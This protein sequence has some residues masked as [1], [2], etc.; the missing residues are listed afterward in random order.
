MFT[1]KKTPMKIVVQMDGPYRVEGEIPLVKKIQVVTEDGEP[2]A[3]KKE[4]DINQT[5]T[6]YLCR[7][8]QSKLKPFCDSTHCEIDFDGRERADVNTTSER[9]EVIPGGIGIVV[10]KDTS[11]CMDSGFCGTKDRSLDEMVP[12]TGDTEIRSNVIAM[13]ERCPS[14][15]YV[16]SV[17]PEELDIEPDLPRQV[18]DTTEITSEGPIRGPL[19]VTGN[20]PIERSDG[21][22]METRNRVTLCSCG[23]S[24]IKPLCDGT[25]RHTD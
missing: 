15:S 16:Y 5:G 25:H 8:G 9:Q 21:K 13:I 18:A 10:K 3:W 23:S 7:C 24:K 4:E 6:Y 20:I 1:T 12:D 22:P 19:W 2:I 14:G 17:P 11:L